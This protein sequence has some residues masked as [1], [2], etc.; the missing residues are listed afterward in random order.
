[1]PMGGRGGLLDPPAPPQHCSCTPQ[2]LYTGQTGSHHF[3]AVSY[4][5]SHDRPTEGVGPGS[6]LGAGRKPHYVTHHIATTPFWPPKG[7]ICTTELYILNALTFEIGPLALMLLR[8]IFF[9]CLLTHALHV[10]QWNKRR[11]M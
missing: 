2:L 6:L 5:L 11:E 10:M 4:P 1:M 7:F 3:H 8:I 9:N